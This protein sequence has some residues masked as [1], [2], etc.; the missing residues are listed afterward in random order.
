M[1][2]Q[3]FLHC[4]ETALCQLSFI[5][6]PRSMDPHDPLIGRGSPF[7][8]VSDQTQNIGRPVPPSQSRPVR[9]P[10]L[11]RGF[12]PRAVFGRQCKENMQGLVPFKPLCLE[13]IHSSISNVCLSESDS[14]HRSGGES[15]REGSAASS[16]ESEMQ[17]TPD[18]RKRRSNEQS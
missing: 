6:T 5:T 18:T 17:D 11:K 4:L 1:V 15:D 10:V 2:W 13:Y 12:P 9:A 14:S 7:A 3:V 16:H 8:N